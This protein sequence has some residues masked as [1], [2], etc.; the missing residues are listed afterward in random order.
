MSWDQNTE[1]DC[2]YY[3]VYALPAS[4]WQPPA[5]VDGWPVAGYTDN[6]G[7]TSITDSLGTSRSIDEPSTGLSRCL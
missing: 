1:E 4:G 7:T 3:A 5:T 2:T 6:C